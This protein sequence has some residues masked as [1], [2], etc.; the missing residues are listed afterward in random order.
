MSCGCHVDVM[1]V[2]HSIITTGDSVLMLHPFSRTHAVGC[3]NVRLR[4][5]GARGTCALDLDLS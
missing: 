1:G 3:C 2:I 4:G 5:G